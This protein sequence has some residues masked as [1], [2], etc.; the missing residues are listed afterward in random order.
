M[1]GVR[2][3]GGIVRQGFNIYPRSSG[4]VGFLLALARLRFMVRYSKVTGWF[5]CYAWR[6][7]AE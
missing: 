3:E 2:D 7:A 6:E 5:D 4:S 1:I